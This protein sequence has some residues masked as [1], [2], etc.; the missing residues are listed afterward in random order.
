MKTP[1]WFR[2][3]FFSLAVL[4]RFSTLLLLASPLLAQQITVDVTPGHATNSFSPL[5]ALGAG[6]DRDPLDSVQILYDPSH[7]QTMLSAGWGPI[8]YRLNTELSIQ[9]WHWNPVGQWSDPAG[10]GYFVGDPNSSG[11]IDRSFG[12]NLPHRGTTSNYGTSGG[13]SVLDDGDLSTYWKSDP[14]LDE[15]YTGEDNL[16]H[17]G[18]ILIDLGSAMGV[19]AI[20]I[21]WANPYATAYE[22]Q[23]WTGDDPIGDPANG[24]WVNFADGSISGGQGGTVTLRL[25]TTKVNVEFVRVLMIASSNTCDTH[26]SMDRRNCLGFAI[27]EVFLGYLDE[28]GTFTDYVNHSPDG[29]QT[30]TYASSIDSW[31][32]PPGIATD[33]G[34]QPGFD[35]VFHSGLT[36]GLPMTIPVAML[37]DNP[38]NA[39]NE[40]AYLEK[41]GYAI[42]YVEMGEEPDGQFVLPEDD[43][44]LFVQWA[45]A[46]HRVDPKIKLAGPVF[47]GVNTDIQA[48]PDAQGGVSWFGR[49]LKYLKQHGHLQDLSVMTFEH[50]P[51]DPCNLHWQNLY[52][53]P[54]LVEHIIK[55]W[56][57]DG[58]PADVPM[59]ITESN[60]AYDT[61][62]EYMQPFGAL[63]LADYAGA[64]LTAGGQALFYYQWEPLP[65]YQGCG[66]WGTFGMFNVD[67]NYNVLQLSSQF[68]SAQML[69]QQWAEPVDRQHVIYPAAS[70]IVNS[71]GN[72]LVTAYSVLRP[73]GR[74]SL[75]LV[76]KDRFTPHSVQVDFHNSAN[77]SDHFFAGEVTQVTFGADNYTWHPHGQRGYANPDGP[78]VTS[79]EPGG[80]GVEYTLPAASVT[81]LRGEVR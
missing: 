37:Y 4:K 10:Q 17:P 62:I 40:I 28:K 67:L 31:H 46:I 7:V 54:Q 8:S 35:H 60:I 69:T 68:F 43:A 21:A 78:A 58:L 32:N 2:S 20:R 70:D 65:M 47:E 55:V 36:R 53:E 18:W 25:S 71:G 73:D 38:D 22:V 30:L 23:Y 50:Y 80:K 61:A 48:W 1:A 56:R 51:F 79:T 66:G 76:N 42:N 16:L 9:A 39:A 27:N 12:Y 15:T 59:Q 11:G 5:R 19:N 64:F 72:V 24:N 52:D 29:G 57:H 13:Y 81:V 6:I 45:D 44:A 34:E 3:S 75:L 14:Y 77:Q 33:D 49:F 63:W 26:G 74:W 41:R